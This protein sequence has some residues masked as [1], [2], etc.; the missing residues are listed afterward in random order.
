MKLDLGK[1]WS[2]AVAKLSANFDVVL[3]VAGVFFFLPYLALMLFLPAEMAELQSGNR[4]PDIDKLGEI[5]LEFYSGFW[6]VFVLIGIAQGIGTLVLMILLSDRARPTLGE[7]LGLAAKLFLPFFAAQ[8]LVGF[9]MGLVMLI[10]IFIGAIGAAS[11]MP[12]LIGVAV[13]V[14]IAA[15]V[16]AIY[17]YTKTSLVAAAVAV[18]RTMNPVEALQQ[19][20]RATKG[21]S[22]MLFFFYLLLVIAIGIVSFMITSVIGLIFAL[23]GPVVAQYGN[24]IVASLVNA[25]TAALMAGIVIS[26]YLQLTGGNVAETRETFE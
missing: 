2:D 20:W 18:E 5:M 13:I 1:A 9:V 14:G 24:G 26:V 10:P 12:L 22:I 25:A 8:L 23:T 15:L 4:Q 21:N 6:W 7:A 11:E 3:V 19:S 16:A 17:I